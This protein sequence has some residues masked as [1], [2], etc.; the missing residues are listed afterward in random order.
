LIKKII[1]LSVNNRLMVFIITALLISLSL[2][3]INKIP[4]DAI[5]DLSD[6]QVIIYS[7][8][9]RSP[10]IIE[11]QVTYPII[12]S[13]LGT[14]KVK[15]IRGFSD[16]GY[17]F[18]YVIF[19]DGTDIYWARSRIIEYMSRIQGYLP[20]GVKTEIGPDATGVGWIFQ[21]II[22]D[23]TNKLDLKDLRSL[24]DF[25]LRY[26]FNAIPGVAEVA[27]IGGYK[28]QYQI[29]IDPS[30]LISYNISL[31]D[32]LEKIKQNN[33]EAGGRVLEIGGAEFMIR[34]RGYI[35]TIDEIKNI[36]IT[37]DKNGIPILL[38]NIANV[39]EGPDMRRGISD[40]NGR[41]DTAGGIIVMRQGENALDVI[42]RIHDKIEE[43]KTSLPEGVEIV[44]VYDR[45]GL[46]KNTISHLK[47]K[48]SEEILIVSL[49]ILIFLW[50]LPSAI[51]PIMTIPISVLLS[52]IPIY[53]TGIGSNL[54]SL[55]GIAISI[56]V[57]VDGAIVE[58]E[59]AYKKIEEWQSGGKIGDYAK[60][61]LEALME[62]GPSV[63]YSLLIIAVSFFPVFVLE[64]QEG[65]LF[66]PLAYSKNFS[67]AIAAIL[68]IT[69]DP[70]IRIL[71]GRIEPIQYFKNDKLNNL[72]TT[73]VV[74]KY[75]PEE[76]HPISNRI[77]KLYEPICRKALVYRKTVIVIPILLFITSIFLYTRLGTEFIPPLYEES[78]LYMPTT[79]PGISVGEADRI[80][81][82]MD[83]KIAKF[84]EVISVYGKAGRADTSTDPA[85]FSMFETVILLKDR[86]EW[87]ERNSF[88]SNFPNWTK[89][90]IGLF[91]NYQITPDEL[92]QLLDNEIQIP[93]FSNAWT[94][95]IRARIDMLS[96]GVR[97][98]IGIK[99]QGPDL[100][101]MEK[102]GIEIEKLLRNDKKVSAVFAE[103]SAGGYYLD[104]EI[105]REQLARYSL[106]IDQIQRVILSAVGGETIVQTIEGR[107]RYTINL[108]YPRDLRDSPEKIKRILVP[109]PSGSHIPLNEFIFIRLKTG[110]S[111]IRDENGFLTSYVFIVPLGQDILGFVEESKILINNHIELPKGYTIIWS[112]QYESLERMKKKM[113]FVIPFTISLIFLLLYFN[114]ASYI[115]TFM[116][117]LAVP[118]SLIGAIFLL[119]IL[120]Y[121]ISM[122]VWI[123]MIALMGLDAETGV[124]MLM[125]LDL[126][127]ETA[128]KNGLMKNKFDLIE[129]I[130]HGAVKRIRPKLMTVLC[131]FLGLL[132]ILWS[133]GTG[134]DLMKRIAAPLVGG[135]FSSFLLELIVYP[136]LYYYWKIRENKF[137]Y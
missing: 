118:L 58:V 10:D 29:L 106:T 77:I 87:R 83:E 9:E 23:T 36:G 20:D 4:L 99:I 79:M 59:N 73:I 45:S 43:I 116:V 120:D 132:P 129:A 5:P 101:E 26:L 31:N 137:N 133:D 40:L 69:L 17:S 55:S 7:K 90:I 22:K 96:T 44:P 111:M 34:S 13:L 100:M 54:M 121:Q 119:Y 14:P 32:V 88:L 27:S 81:K 19:Q 109:T 64:E 62:V 74:G 1:R 49:I 35:K 103:R 39:S 89:K 128:L 75:Y 130:V 98:P 21:Y 51:I 95:P 107:E 123:G 3:Y 92:I 76:K 63:F 24:Q 46:I 53:W 25:K 85:P 97:T 136:V 12:T 30:K 86:S 78:I 65:R 2:Y 102:I 94:M 6:T 122:A 93:G 41:G 110:P 37:S 80:L 113:K 50:H 60:I 67:M 82:I 131:A 108:R 15:T 52:F 117:M 112:G 134:A 91:Y 61:R 57:L 48:L 71:F 84:P 16:Y 70:A 115:K 105:R 135:L 68:A 18:V 8:W 72:L 66:H 124:F 42:Q 127:Y 56:G 126:S 125:Y 11:D 114:T 47:W 28:K 38:Q 33:S 104:I